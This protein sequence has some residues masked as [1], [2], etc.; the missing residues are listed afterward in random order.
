MPKTGKNIRSDFRNNL[1]IMIPGWFVPPIVAVC[2]LVVEFS[3]SVLV[4]L[5]VFCVVAFW[6]LPETSKEHCEG[7]ETV[8]CPP[9]SKAVQ[10]SK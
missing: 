8:D 10:A 2:L 4:L 9:R 5:V 3:W 6:L 7:C 1:Y